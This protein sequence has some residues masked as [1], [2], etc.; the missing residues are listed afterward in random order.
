MRGERFGDEGE[1][2]WE[3]EVSTREVCDEWSAFLD[4]PDMYDD[5]RRHNTSESKVLSLTAG[6]G[7]CPPHTPPWLRCSKT[8]PF[9]PNVPAA[10][11]QQRPPCLSTPGSPRAPKALPPRGPPRAPL[12]TDPQLLLPRPPPSGSA[13]SDGSCCSWGCPAP[14]AASP[15]P[16]ERQRQPLPCKGGRGSINSGAAAAAAS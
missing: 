13:W 4:H 3:E 7:L 2:G 1:V 6:L 15:P 16:W 14:Q 9:A 5:R 11:Q 12:L 10:W 8:L